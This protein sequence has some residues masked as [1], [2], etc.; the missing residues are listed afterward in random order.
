MRVNIFKNTLKFLEIIDPFLAE[1]FH[2]ISW[3]FFHYNFKI[4]EATGF[5]FPEVFFH[6]TI[7]IA[8]KFL[9]F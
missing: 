2:D 7:Y 9:I 8:A 3:R 5:N 4:N 6:M 1:V